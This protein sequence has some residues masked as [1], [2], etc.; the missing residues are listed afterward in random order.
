[1]SHYSNRPQMVRVDFF[2]ESG[3]W[4]DTI[5]ME[6]L[7]YSGRMLI[8]DAFIRSLQACCNG[9]YYDMTAVCLKPYHENSHPVMLHTWNKHQPS[10]LKL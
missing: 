9:F 2:K 7:H 1:M 10:P 3:K 8:H 6:W 5:E 4:Y